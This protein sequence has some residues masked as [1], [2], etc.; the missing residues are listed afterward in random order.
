VRVLITQRVDLLTE[1]GER[2][3]ALDQAWGNTLRGML[4]SPALIYPMPNRSLDVDKTVAH[5]RPSLIVLSGGN[6]IGNA[7]ERDATEAALLR[8][9]TADRIPVLAV[10]RGMLMVQH[11]LGGGL[12]RLTDHVAVEHRVRSV[13][14]DASPHEFSVNSFHAWGIDRG[15]LANGLQAL[16]CHS[17]GSVEAARHATLPWLS[18]MWHPE[19]PGNGMAL[20]NDWAGRWLCE[21]L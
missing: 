17:D 12:Q 14:E 20:A 9:A 13:S 1:R 6:D 7:P 16:Y 3:D 5:L 10:C 4:Q 19:R 18:L 11:F 8:R 15:A 21:V 2:R